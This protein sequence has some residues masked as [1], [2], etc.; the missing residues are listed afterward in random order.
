MNSTPWFCQ[1]DDDTFVNVPNMLSYLSKFV[2]D[3]EVLYIGRKLIG[4]KSAFA[5][6][7]AWC[8]SRALVRLGRSLFEDLGQAPGPW[9][10]SDDMAI[11]YIVQVMLNV[12]MTDERRM[13]SHLEK[14]KFASQSE[15]KQQ[16][17]YG[18]G[19][20]RNGKTNY[21]FASYPGVSFVGKEGGPPEDPLGFRGLFC[22]L[23]PEECL[24]T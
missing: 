4:G 9:P 17:A 3:S 14:Q 10:V 7:A 13:H 11:G 15:M 21:N 5:P 24:L 12:T 22:N 2:A 8:L 20:K 18:S 1:F 19:G 6:G 23:W 16:L